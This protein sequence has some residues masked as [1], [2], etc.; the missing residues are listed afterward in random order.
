MTIHGQLSCPL[1]VAWRAAHGLA[2]LSPPFNPPF[3]PPT[4]SSL[5]AAN[6]LSRRT[7]RR[8][9][10]LR[11]NKHRVKGHGGRPGRRRRR[12]ETIRIGD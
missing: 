9:G 10:R 1:W 6:D 2:R 8:S 11:H 3:S 12:R 7:S 5:T 4:A